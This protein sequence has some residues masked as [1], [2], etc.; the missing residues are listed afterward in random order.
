MEKKGN[1]EKSRMMNRIHRKTIRK[2]LGDFVTKKEVEHT[3]K[4]AD[5]CNP[6]TSLLLLLRN[7]TRNFIYNRFCTGFL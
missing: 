1:G 5:R 2:Y 6:G 7:Q 4:E 3:C